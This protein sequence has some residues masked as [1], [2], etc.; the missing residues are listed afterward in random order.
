[1]NE[2]TNPAAEVIDAMTR[3]KRLWGTMTPE[4]RAEWRAV[5]D[6]GKGNSAIH[7]II[8]ERLNI[9]L[10]YV[11]YVTRFREWVEEPEGHDLKA[12]KAGKRQ[13]ELLARGMT[14][15]QAQETI[16]NEAVAYSLAGEDYALATRV[17][18]EITRFRALEL[19]RERFE[20][21]AA[22][23]CLAKW[24][25]LISLHEDDLLEEDEKI[26]QVRLKLFGSA[27]A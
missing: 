5:L 21:N 2:E 4:T 25:E 17:C 1:M 24:P 22:K 13:A 20:F 3:L 16:L 7:K 23:A 19:G 27:P 26:R 8:K 15:A 12:E 18:A 14:L 11:N 9:D 10:P 6:S